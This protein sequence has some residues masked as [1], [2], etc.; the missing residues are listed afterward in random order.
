MG[1]SSRIIDPLLL[2]EVKLELGKALCFVAGNH[3]IFRDFRLSEGSF[4]IEPWHNSIDENPL[5]ATIRLGWNL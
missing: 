2:P 4:I 5:Y 1:A 3:S